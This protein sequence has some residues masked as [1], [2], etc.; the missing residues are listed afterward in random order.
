VINPTKEEI[1]RENGNCFKRYHFCMRQGAQGRCTGMTLRDGMGREVGG[2]FRMGDTC[3]PMAD[4]CQCMA[5][6]TTIL[7]SNQPP[8]KIN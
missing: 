8:I 2:G 4:S 1:F 5:K 7:Y 6:T 3:T